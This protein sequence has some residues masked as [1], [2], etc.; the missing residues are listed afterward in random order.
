MDREVVAAT[1]DL[2]RRVLIILCQDAPAWLGSTWLGSTWLG[3]AWLGNSRRANG[4]NREQ[5]KDISPS[6]SR[7]F[8]H[9]ACFLP[10]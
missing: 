7:R 1:Q 8:C 10:D 9:Y 6:G 4:N 3:P 5:G 2:F